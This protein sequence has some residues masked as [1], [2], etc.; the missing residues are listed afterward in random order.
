MSETK[1]LSLKVLVYNNHMAQRLL[2][3]NMKNGETPSLQKLYERMGYGFGKHNNAKESAI[4]DLFS[5]KIVPTEENGA[6]KDIATELAAALECKPEELWPGKLRN[7]IPASASKKFLVNI[8]EPLEWLV[9][10]S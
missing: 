6:W 1:D 5:L 9:M 8:G 2:Q 3:M 7:D 4:R 10:K